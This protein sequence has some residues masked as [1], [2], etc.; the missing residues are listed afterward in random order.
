MIQALRIHLM[1][2]SACLC[3]WYCFY[4]HCQDLDL[5]ATKYGGEKTYINAGFSEME[6]N[7]KPA[8]TGSHAVPDITA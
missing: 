5:S 4:Y 2:R 1:I 3:K 6:T 7:T 8:K